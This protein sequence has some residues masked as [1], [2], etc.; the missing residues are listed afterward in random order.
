MKDPRSSITKCKHGVY[1]PLNLPNSA[2]SLC[3]P[4]LISTEHAKYLILQDPE[5]GHW[6]DVKQQ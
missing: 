4:I 2:C 5:T 3:Q 1:M 6:Q